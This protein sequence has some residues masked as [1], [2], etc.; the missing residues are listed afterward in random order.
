MG[1]IPFSFF[2]PIAYI[3]IIFLLLNKVLNITGK[4]IEYSNTNE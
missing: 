2:I 1:K 4:Y 3:I